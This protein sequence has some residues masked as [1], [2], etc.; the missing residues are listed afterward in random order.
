MRAITSD[1]FRLETTADQLCQIA[2]LKF[3][4]P[5]RKTSRDAQQ[6]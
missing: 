1:R 3:D 6:T 5:A 2:A 4:L